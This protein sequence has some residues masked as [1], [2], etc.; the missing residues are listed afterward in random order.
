MKRKK[1]QGKKTLAHI[2]SIKAQRAIQ[3][4]MLRARARSQAKLSMRRSINPRK[5][6]KHLPFQRIFQNKLVTT[7][8]NPPHSILN[9]SSFLK[10]SIHTVFSFPNHNFRTIDLLF[11]SLSTSN[12]WCLACL[13]QR[14]WCRICHNKWVCTKWAALMNRYRT[15]S[16]AKWLPYAGNRHKCS[17]RSLQT[18]PIWCLRYWCIQT[19][20][21]PK[22][23][24]VHSS[25]LISINMTFWTHPPTPTTIMTPTIHRWKARIKMRLLSKA[26]TS[27]VGPNQR[28][29]LTQR[30]SKYLMRNRMKPQRIII[31][32]A[33]N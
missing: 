23:L 9:N 32:Q 16:P 31:N 6:I 2:T 26:M 25:T 12:N 5:I 19:Q 18:W 1:K 3:R 14:I 29:C 20:W 27:T 7:I 22:T 33:E 28:A 30:V 11:C 17:H 4:R 21:T 13:K 10:P 24:N 8:S 15:L